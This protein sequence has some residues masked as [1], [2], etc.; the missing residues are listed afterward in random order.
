MTIVGNGR[1]AAREAR[2]ALRPPEAMF[3]SLTEQLGNIR[4][5]NTERRW[6]F[7]AA[8]FHSVD[9]TPRARKDPLVV[10]V[11]AIYLPDTAECSG[12]LR[13]CQELWTVAAEQ[14]PR[15]WSWDWYR[16]SWQD[17][18]KPVRLID[19]L[20]HRPGIRRVTLDLS[21]GYVPGRHVRPSTL[22]GPNSAHAEVLAAA[23]H[24][25]RWVRAM[26]GDNVPYA[27]LLGY[28][29]MMR[30]QRTPLRLPALSWNDLRQ[31]M[32][33]TAAWVNQSFSGWAAPVCLNRR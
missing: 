17:I 30:G 10:D 11:V 6:G 29:V 27:W 23:A 33:L 15:S 2:L 20:V 1:V 28:E 24:F 5:W 19:G 3:T 14:Q 7:S 32:S 12:V 8:D 13:T 18:P 4:R 25:P 22:R 9:L 16:D 26:D 21:A 31:T